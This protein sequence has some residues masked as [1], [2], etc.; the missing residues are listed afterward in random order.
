MSAAC[1][2][3]IDCNGRHTFGERERVGARRVRSVVRAHGKWKLQTTGV[4][5]ISFAASGGIASGTQTA[6]R[7]RRACEGEIDRDIVASNV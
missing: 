6:C 2:S 3:D 1:T 4:H 5:L 7:I